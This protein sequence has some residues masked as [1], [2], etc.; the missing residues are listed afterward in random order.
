MQ[1]KINPIIPNGEISA[2][3][4]KSDAHR[5]IICA[6]L[7]DNQTNIHISHTSKDIEA[8]LNCIKTLGAEFS[9][10]DNVFEITPVNKLL[11]N[12]ILD[13][14]ESGSTLRFLFP[15][16]SALGCGAT[17]TGKGRLPERPMD[18][19]VDLLKEHGNNF[20]SSTLPITISGKTTTGIFEIPGNV[21]SQFISGLL[22]ALPLLDKKCTIRL[23]SKLQSSSY[24]NMTIDTMKRFGACIS[25]NDSEFITEPIKSY[26]SP[27]EYIVE[28]DWSNAAFF[29]VM[30]AL[31]GDT[32]IKNLNQNSYQSD[33][34]ILDL[35]SLAGIDYKVTENKAE[36]FKSQINPFQ[37]DVSE[38]PDLF[39]VLSI[40][41]CGANGKSILYNAKRL[42]IKES[43]R[44]KSTKELILNL[45]GKA[46]ETEDS[47]IIYGNGKLYG[48][49]VNSYN[50]HRIAMSAY[51]ASAICENDVILND[52]KAIDKS[53][54]S[55]M[56]DFRS[57]GG[58]ADVIWNWKEN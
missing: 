37:F 2:I 52:A 39:P 48:G 49:T 28:G 13:C 57:I 30:G 16:I 23:T 5:A 8:T 38:C 46:E 3:A 29:M 51:V 19:I 31:G 32:T 12:P 50:D 10:K 18:L 35:F 42:R 20:S 11:E 27:K 47:L 43:D 36:V 22:F 41:A 53:Y 4:S 15:I 54:P 14:N 34:M 55:F 7:A 21:S 40:L 44:I 58:K 17:F 26:K 56:D 9:K 24:V 33:K 45:G 1:V 6:S 25:H